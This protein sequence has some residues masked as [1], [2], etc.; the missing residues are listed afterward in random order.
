MNAAA[1]EPVDLM[2]TDDPQDRNLLEITAS[3]PFWFSTAEPD[4]RDEYIRQLVAYHACAHRLETH[5]EDV[6][7]SFDDY[8]REHVAARIKTDIGFA[9]DPDLVMIDLPKRVF[10][11][12]QMD[13]QHGRVMNYF[14]PWVAG[15]ERESV[16][17]TRL[18]QRN[19]PTDDEQMSARFQFA[20]VEVG[21]EQDTSL[22]SAAY[23]HELVAQLNVTQGYRN[24]LA[25]VFTVPAEGAEQSHQDADLLLEP[26][27]RQIQLQGL[28]Q[29]VRK[30]LSEEGYR[31]LTLAA[32][33]R[34]RRETDAAGLEMNW[35]QLKPGSSVSG[36]GDERTLSGLCMI[37]DQLSERTL[38][39]LPDAAGDI[40][41][42]EETDPVRARSRLIQ[43]LISQP[44]LV[45]YLAERS[46]EENTERHVSYINQALARGFEGFIRFVPALDLQLAAQQLHTR[47]WSL[48]R[49]TRQHARSKSD[50]D[51]E[52]SQQQNDTYLMYFRAILAL[53]PGLG[54]LISVQDGWDAGH[55]AA[56]AFREGRLDD[57]MM[58][59]GVA[60]MSVLDV[61]FSIIP[62]VASIGVLTRVARR[63]AAFRAV[64]PAHRQPV[65]RPFEGYEV[66]VSLNGA[67][68]QSGRDV[69][70]VLKDGQLWMQ[71]Q[72]L[73]YAVYRRRGE[74]TLRL[75]KTSTQG[76]EP[77]VRLEA[78]R[79]VYH[80]DVGLLGGV[81][82]SIAETLIAQA[83]GDPVL[84]K[85]HARQLLDQYQ[86]PLVSQRRMELDVAVHY[87][88]HRAFPGW[89]DA[90]R[91]ADEPSQALPQPGGQGSKRKD[92]PSTQSEV[93]RTAGPGG[94]MVAG[95]AGGPDN[96]KQWAR[97]LSDADRLDQVGLHPPIFRLA[98][99]QG[100]GFI[101]IHGARYD[102]LPAGASQHPSIVFL[103]NP[104]VL[105]ESFSGFNETIRRNRYDQPVMASFKDGEWSVHGPLFKL[106]IQYLVEQARPGMTPATNRIL[107]EKLFERADFGHTG[108]TASRMI[109]MKATLNAWRREQLAPLANLNDP[110]L[111]LEGAR[112][113]NVGTLMPRLRISYGPSF[114][115]FNRVDFTVTQPALTNMLASAINGMNLGPAGKASMRQFMSTLLTDAGYSIVSIDQ[116]LLQARSLLLF[117]RVGH[118][119]LYLLN[120]HHFSSSSPAFQLRHVDNAI[121]MSNRWVH[122]WLAGHPAKH[123]LEA[124]ALARAEGRLVK[125]VGGIRASSTA[126]SGTQVFVQRLADD[127]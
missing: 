71:R 11:D 90:Y 97:P 74:Q 24:R 15:I 34:S 40:L 4:V 105:D 8:V 73:V 110:L 112:M 16:S 125:L 106:K 32:Q 45:G 61:A 51:I 68:A 72:N 64:S 121:P 95:P 114:L 1:L 63:G 54:S 123:E 88:K 79:W 109:N 27:E 9:V 26:Y 2:S 101:Q 99:E 23:L 33:A 127:I 49:M 53:L 47:S 120:M 14:S 55:Q 93:R 58:A 70:T 60:A 108:L 31:M 52:R 38:I 7:P 92:P 115:S 96:W 3:L 77:P 59:A 42:I 84:Q 21:E 56:R 76:Y 82:S 19:L 83:H 85:R 91:R 13:P 116:T 100:Q 5:L 46:L 43:K 65:L 37:R 35:V 104:A 66:Q 22:L 17:L 75:K 87:Q 118:D 57:G 113:S 44:A 81:R 94:S 12:Y 29:F 122:E 126:E 69:G 117:Q 119:S 41:L 102:I 67:L 36:E 18:A 6:L 86:F 48:H 124:V 103:R 10:R 78:G 50:L 80:S 89:A 111:M 25:Q 98:D 20:E 39:Y 28:C 62:G 30:R 107:A